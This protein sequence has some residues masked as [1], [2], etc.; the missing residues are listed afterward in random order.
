MS[1][2]QVI[3][4]RPVSLA[5]RVVFSALLTSVLSFVPILSVDKQ[6]GEQPSFTRG[7]ENTRTSV[8]PGHISKLCHLPTREVHTYGEYC[9]REP[10]PCG[11]KEAA[12]QR[13]PTALFRPCAGGHGAPDPYIH[14]SENQA[15]C[16]A[17]NKDH[18]LCSISTLCGPLWSSASRGPSALVLTVQR[19]C[20]TCAG[21]GNGVPHSEARNERSIDNENATTSRIH[22]RLLLPSDWARNFVSQ[23]F[24]NVEF[25]T[26]KPPPGMFA[27]LRCL[28]T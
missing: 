24:S 13:T 27:F 26:R 5:A 3:R 12:P 25:T 16:S 18:S 23:I 11:N 15:P 19:M 21:S 9:G 2:A 20:T 10:L 4:Y 8:R 22:G 7:F 28:P 17:I 1:R 6:K 14:P